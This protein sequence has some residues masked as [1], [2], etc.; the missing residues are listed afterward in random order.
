MCGSTNSS[1]TSR[2]RR[3]RDR[4]TLPALVLFTL[5]T[6]AALAAEPPVRRIDITHDTTSIEQVLTGPVELLATNPYGDG[7]VSLYVDGAL[8]ASR[9]TPP[10]LFAIDFGPTPAERRLSFKWTD[11]SGRKKKSWTVEVNEGARPLTVTLES[12][13]H[14]PLLLRA[15]VTSP[16]ND[17]IETVTFQMGEQVIATFTSPP[18]ETRLDFMPEQVVHAIARSRSGAEANDFLAG[19]RRVEVANF[20]VRQVPLYIS[21]LD[22]K[23]SAKDG[24]QASQF[25]ILDNGTEAKIVEFGRAFDQPLSLA[26]VLDTSASMTNVLTAA[27]EAANA[28]LTNVLRP[29]D[30]IA[31]FTIGGAARRVTHLTDDHATAA[32]TLENLE[33][34]GATALFDGVEGALRELASENRR[35]AIVVLS[36]GADTASFFS[37][38]EV[39]EKAR[40]AAIPIYFIAFNGEE[41]DRAVDQAK[42]LS[43]ETGGFLAIAG[44]EN[45]EERY[46]Q[47]EE[48]LRAQY[49]VKYQIV[50]RVEQDAWRPV[51]VILQSP[52]LTARTVR[53]Y[54][55]P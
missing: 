4:G 39:F 23:G 6:S 37:Y 21:V 33:A 51:R 40:R 26:L 43:L 55:T 34:L 9:S 14:D 32:K 20:Q 2:K 48:D 54:F 35:R 25:R 16:S 28:F 1:R 29:G 22:Q 49:R 12:D 17:P 44:V 15:R 10:Y 3:R 47:I 53:G 18:F 42:A 7:K 11:R 46:R 19:G 27:E 31:L 36:D 8:L 24:L 45:L 13:L 30:R 52:R 50:D 41:V 38:D 5:L